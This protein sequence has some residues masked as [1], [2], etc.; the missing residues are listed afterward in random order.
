MSRTEDR[1]PAAAAEHGAGGQGAV[2]RRGRW[3]GLLVAVALAC[4]LVPVT[5]ALLRPP[6]DAGAPL[7]AALG[8]AAT[9]AT[10]TG[11]ATGPDSASAATPPAPAPAA[12]PVVVRDAS[13][14]AAR[15]ARGPDPVRLQVPSLGVDAAVDAVGV[16]T[17]GSMVVPAQVDRVGWYRFGPRAG[18]PEG[19]TVLAGH[20]DTAAD[21]P[22]A[23]FDLRT[24]EIG[25]EVTV[26]DADG[27]DHRYQ[28]TSR[29]VITKTALPVEQIFAR[30]G[31]HRLVVI[32]CGGAFVPSTRSYEDN[33]VVTAVPLP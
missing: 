23:L 11:T 15:T 31:E 19:N 5:W 22:G 7:D 14:A 3:T 20:V 2:R 18:A 6:P 24:I 27:T 21:G 13:V 28:V 4:V 25:A 26:T 1:R 10:A 16:E 8:Q 12:P 30:T 32:T 9:G 17:D 33:V 29:D